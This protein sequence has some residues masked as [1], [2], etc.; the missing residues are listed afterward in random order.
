M[1]FSLLAAQPTVKKDWNEAIPIHTYK[2][3]VHVPFK[4]KH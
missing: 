2:I 1:S 3:M 4:P